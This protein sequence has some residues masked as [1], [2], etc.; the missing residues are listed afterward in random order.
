MRCHLSRLTLSSDLT[1]TIC[2]SITTFNLKRFPLQ[3]KL[4]KKLLI[5]FKNNFNKQSNK[6]NRKFF[7]SFNST[8]TMISLVDKY[9]VVVIIHDKYKCSTS[10]FTM[11]S[12]NTYF[13]NR[14]LICIYDSTEILWSICTKYKATNDSETENEED[15]LWMKLH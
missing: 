11:Y 5:Y 15:C 13:K 14:M 1:S 6:D 8:K 9:T 12:Y 3:V 7:T 4:F 10:K 2:T